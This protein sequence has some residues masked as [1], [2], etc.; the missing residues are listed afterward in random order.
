MAKDPTEALLLLP[1]YN[2]GSLQ[3]IIETADRENKS[4][5]SERQCLRI[6]F[7][8]CLGVLALHKEKL[9]HRDIKPANVLLS[10]G[11]FDSVQPVLT[12]LGSVSSSKVNIGSRQDASMLEVLI[13]YCLV[14]SDQVCSV[15][16][17][18]VCSGLFCLIWS[19]LVWSG[20]VWSGLV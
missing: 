13:W 6:F 14:C 4:A 18:V 5:F 2:K 17:G 1:L 8:L 7:E 20:L 10:A 11:D 16:S 15:W 9:S 3:G 12:D 19:G